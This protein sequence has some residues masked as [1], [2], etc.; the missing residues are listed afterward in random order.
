MFRGSAGFVLIFGIAAIAGITVYLIIQAA[1][2]GGV[3]GFILGLS[4]FVFIVTVIIMV[5]LTINDRIN[6]STA[7]MRD[8]R[9]RR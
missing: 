3:P 9:T 7:R 2:I 8:H 6:S 4:M 5:L 1:G